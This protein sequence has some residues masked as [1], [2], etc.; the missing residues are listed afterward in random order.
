MQHNEQSYLF[1]FKKMN[2]KKSDN[3]G[4]ENLPQDMMN[5]ISSYL[6]YNPNLKN[7][8]LVSKQL[9]WSI[10][11]TPAGRVARQ[12]NDL[13]PSG[14]SLWV[15]NPNIFAIFLIAF[16]MIGCLVGATVGATAFSIG[17]FV[18]GGTSFCVPGAGLLGC[19]VGINGGLFFG[20]L[21]STAMTLKNLNFWLATEVKIDNIRDT[22]RNPLSKTKSV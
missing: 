16:P 11:N 20:G 8:R 2:S 15:K 22:L 6:S 5:V 21:G 3:C 12:A 17:I 18:G 4:I 10:E 9:N 19:E 7:L 14:I 1:I 13:E